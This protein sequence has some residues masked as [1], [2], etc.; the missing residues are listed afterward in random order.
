MEYVNSRLLTNTHTDT[1]VRYDMVKLT[2]QRLHNVSKNVVASKS[3]HD[4]LHR[5]AVT[6]RLHCPAVTNNESLD[7]LQW[8]IGVRKGQKKPGRIETRAD[9][10]D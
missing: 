3:R 9:D 8:G 4:R 10:V 6:A 7:G 5:H 2:N 1:V